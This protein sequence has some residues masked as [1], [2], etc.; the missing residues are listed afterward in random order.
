MKIL[1]LQ[2]LLWVL[3]FC[4]A[5]V[6]LAAE[7]TWPLDKAPIDLTDSASL[8]RGAQIY[9]N[10]CLSCHGLR[11]NRYD[12]LAKQIDI[13]NEE[14]ELLSDVVKENLQFTG[15]KLTDPIVST[16]A[17]QDGINWFGTAPP[18]LSLVARSRGVDW[19]YTYLRTFY[20]DPDK[21]WGVN[22]LVFPDVGM[23]HVLLEMQGIQSPKYKEVP[24]NIDGKLEVHKVIDQLVL[25]TP[26]QLEPVAFDQAM[27]DLVNFLAYVAEPHQLE[28]K[29]LGMWVLVFLSIF[30]VIS[31][32]LKREYWKEVK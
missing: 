28:R 23:P 2:L 7:A 32:L 13:T 30:A 4:S 29:R 25:T 6:V 31:Y 1:R 18:D 21:T 22:N 12:T 11:F 8:Q 15:E 20:Q 24:V 17:K 16:I 5:K 27:G 26:G 19:L 3:C 14:G 9:M 10:H